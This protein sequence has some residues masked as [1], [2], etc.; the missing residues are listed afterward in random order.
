MSILTA[1]EIV[2]QHG[3][4]RRLNTV[5]FNVEAGECVGIL[6]P[7]G[8][9]K[10]TLLRT[11][12]GLQVPN[13]G[14]VLF[15]SKRWAEISMVEFSKAVGYLPQNATFHWP[16]LVEQAVKLGRL[17]HQTSLVRKTSKDLGAINR[18]IDT[19]EIREFIDCRVDKISGGERMRVHL[20]RLLAGEHRVI[21]ADEPTASLDPKYQLHFLEVLKRQA[22]QG[23]AVVLSLHDLSLAARFCDRLVVL[24]N[25]AVAVEGTPEQALNDRTLGTVFG[26]QA[27]R[28]RTTTGVSIVPTGALDTAK[29]N[30]DSAD[31]I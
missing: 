2:V 30:D 3:H 17:P 22:L 16:I 20:A 5:C 24:D 25:G 11:L 10:T 7:N 27:T 23:T 26:V 6:G 29:S 21:V 14:D 28:V 15:E 12:L 4:R 1:H 31:N 8:S 9:G 19:A 18:A 13:S